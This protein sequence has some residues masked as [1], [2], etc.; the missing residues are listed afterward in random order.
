MTLQKCPRCGRSIPD[1]QPVHLRCL[2]DRVWQVFGIPIGVLVVVLVLFFFVIPLGNALSDG[3]TLLPNTTPTVI[4]TTPLSSATVTA[5]PPSEMSTPVSGSSISIQLPLALTSTAIS[6][7]PP[8]TVAVEASSTP[9]SD[10]QPATATAFPSD[11]PIPS[12]TLQPPTATPNQV[13]LAN[14][15]TG[16]TN[17]LFASY[18]ENT[19]QGLLM[20]LNISSGQLVTLA[21]V[22]GSVFYS[23]MSPDEKNIVFEMCYAARCNLY[24]LNRATT[25]VN[26]LTTNGISRVPRWNPSGNQIIFSVETTSGSHD[27]YTIRPNGTDLQRL[28]DGYA[29]SFSPD[30]TSI[31]FQRNVYGRDHIFTMNL[32]TKRTSARYHLRTPGLQSHP[33]RGV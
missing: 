17:V 32:S 21:S 1:W 26:Q 33:G 5:S 12:P 10:N 29:P 27:I 7:N 28:T 22:K 24:V 16:S 9:F 25:A 23:D 8:Q 19:S 14:N 31:V 2:F 11:T 18:D 20:T 6:L 3:H 13:A 30:G 4:T 15:Q